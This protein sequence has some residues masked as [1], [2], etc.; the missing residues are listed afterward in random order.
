MSSAA[1]DLSLNVS[2][3]MLQSTWFLKQL[4]SII[5]CHVLQMLVHIAEEDPEKWVQGQ[6]V[7]GNMFKLGAVEGVKNCDK[8][9]GLM[10]FGTNQR[11]STSLD[12]VSRVQCAR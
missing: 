8:L 1:E 5:L 6:K 10:R 4:H 11:D 12:K 3:E 2:C 9:V 7:Y